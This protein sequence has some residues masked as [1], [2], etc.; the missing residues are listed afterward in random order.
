M[1][2]FALL[3]SLAVGEIMAA[4]DGDVD[5]VEATY[6]RPAREAAAMFKHSIPRTN[7][8]APVLTYNLKYEPKEVA[9]LAVY[10]RGCSSLDEK[11]NVFGAVT[12]SSGRMLKFQAS[13]IL[14]GKANDALFIF[15]W[16]S[17]ED[18]FAKVQFKLG[19]GEVIHMRANEF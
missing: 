13:P 11:G 17:P 6:E 15:V 5:D 4:V 14:D 2:A 3:T 10:V 8:E 7:L 1:M 16:E 12:D 9:A 19:S 18:G